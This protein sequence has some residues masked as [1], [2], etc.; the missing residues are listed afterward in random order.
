MLR[1]IP[2]APLLVF[3]FVN[4]NPL[5]RDWLVPF[6]QQLLQHLSL[7]RY[8]RIVPFVLL[9]LI[10][11]RSVDPLFD[12]VFTL[13]VV[14]L[15]RFFLSSLLLYP[16]AESLCDEGPVLWSVLWWLRHV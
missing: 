12:V 13:V 5:T 7:D 4:V 1:L 10:L 8:G 2:F 9:P 14:H 15:T 6:V 11:A 16:R 3:V